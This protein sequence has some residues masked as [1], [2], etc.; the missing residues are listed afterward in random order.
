MLFREAPACGRQEATKQSL[1]SH[2]TLK[3]TVPDFV[4]SAQSNDLRMDNHYIPSLEKGD[5]IK[6]PPLEKGGE[7]GFES[8]LS[9]KL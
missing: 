8:V 6:F 2:P 5:T 1:K 7:G 4:V 9:P 3:E